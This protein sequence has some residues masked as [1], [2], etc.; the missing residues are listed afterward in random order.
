[1]ESINNNTKSA[2]E[3]IIC[4]S[5]P[6]KPVVTQC[7]H[8]FCWKCLRQWVSQR[9][10]AECPI[11]KSGV[12]MDKVISLYTNHDKPADDRYILVNNSDRADDVPRPRNNRV[13]PVRNNSNFFRSFFFANN[14]TYSSN[15]E[16]QQNNAYVSLLV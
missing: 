12:E 15:E 9:T 13:D 1:M 16:D 11:C 5:P 2:L 7:G 8:V 10:Y 14:P 4:L 6:T 3:C